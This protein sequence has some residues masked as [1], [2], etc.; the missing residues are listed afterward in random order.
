MKTI[1]IE[2]NFARVCPGLKIGIIG[3]QVTNTETMF[4]LLIYYICIR[5][6][7]GLHSAYSEE[8]VSDCICTFLACI[9]HN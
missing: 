9:E 2:N 6:E 1:R 8:F 7:S 5:C 4:F 3:A